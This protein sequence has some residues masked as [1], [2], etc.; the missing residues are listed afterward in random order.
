MNINQLKDSKFLRKEDC[1]KGILVTIDKIEQFNV[2]PDGKPEE[3]K[4]CIVFQED[5]K[6]FVTGPTTRTLVAQ[7]VGSEETDDWHGRQI[8]L[9]HDPSIIFAGKVT[10]GIRPRAP[11]RPAPRSAPARPAPRPAPV[12]AQPEPE[13]ELPE[14]DD[15]P[16]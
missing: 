15:V 9:Y 2:A 1:G 13:P 10:G 5:V 11:Q 14:D 16:F 4:W 7:I 12:A 3:L 6:P 8:V